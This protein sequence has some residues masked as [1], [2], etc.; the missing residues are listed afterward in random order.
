MERNAPHSYY[1]LTQNSRPWLYI[2]DPNL[3]EKSNLVRPNDI[4]P[5][6]LNVLFNIN[7]LL[8]YVSIDL[9]SKFQQIYPYINI[10][11]IYAVSFI[12]LLWSEKWNNYQL[13]SLQ[14]KGNIEQRL[15]IMIALRMF[16]VCNDVHVFLQLWISK[17]RALSNLLSRLLCAMTSKLSRLLEKFVFF[18][19][20]S[21]SVAKFIISFKF[22][23][24]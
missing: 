11:C 9:Q 4:V 17:E 24:P 1:H 16:F 3:S 20:F 5:N 8:T 21:N 15:F 14:V 19:V 18:K 2:S 6:N 23:Q 7:H 12:P 13:V 22:Q 10:L